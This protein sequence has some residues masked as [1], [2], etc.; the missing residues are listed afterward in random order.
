MFQKNRQIYIGALLA[1]CAACSGPPSSSSRP[2]DASPTDAS[3]VADAGLSLPPDG[4]SDFSVDMGR[5]QIDLSI[6]EETFGAT[7]CE[8]EPGE[9]CVAAAGT[10]RVLRF[11]VETINLGEGDIVLGNPAENPNYDFSECHGHFHFRGYASYRLLGQG[12]AEVL[13][14]RKQAFCLLDSEPYTEFASED[15]AFNCFNQGLSAGWADV[16]AADLPCQFLDITDVPDG[17]YILEV[18]VNPD[19]ILPDSDTTNNVGSI[20]VSIG[21]AELGT[22]TEACPVMDSR[23]LDRIQ[24]ECDWDFVSAFPCEPGTLT[25]AGCAQNC[26]LG[27]CTGDPMLRVCD[28]AEA[29]CTSGVALGANDNRCG[30][31]CPMANDFLCPESGQLA[32][33]SASIEHGQPYTCDVVLGA[34]PISP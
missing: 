33:Y 1:A 12:R 4:S 27:S 34:G 23:Y 7:S 9:E 2:V 28:G 16:Y 31:A 21:D 11:S 30:G 15:R 24:R 29:N 32:V 10:R 14:G 20:A 3:R 18:A 19:G 5:S 13:V 22:P 25:G 26:G 8:L 6:G 17:D